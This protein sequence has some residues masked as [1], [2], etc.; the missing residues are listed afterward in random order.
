MDN[1][2]IVQTEYSRLYLRE[3]SEKNS[4]NRG[5]QTVSAGKHL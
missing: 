3:H 4:R 2:K 1:R 5:L